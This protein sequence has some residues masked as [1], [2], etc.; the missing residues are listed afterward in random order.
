MCHRAKGERMIEVNCNLERHKARVRDLLTSRDGLRHRSARP[1][2]VER[3]F[4]CLKSAK[5][6]RRFLC[7]GLDMVSLY[8]IWI[9]GY[10]TQYLE[11][12]S[13]ESV[14]YPF[15]WLFLF[16]QILIRY[17]MSY[18]HNISNMKNPPLIK[19]ETGSYFHAFSRTHT[20][21]NSRSISC[22]KTQSTDPSKV[23]CVAF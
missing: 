20:G 2:Q 7:R 10:C 14:N 6:F 13:Q 17:P 18:K 21:R 5:T 22:G 19:F 9:V 4:A 16:S 3:A 23:K 12:G 15:D 8:R 1:A 11:N